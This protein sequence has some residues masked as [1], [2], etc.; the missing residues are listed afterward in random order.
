VIKISFVHD[1]G[2]PG[3]VVRDDEKR[4]LYCYEFVDGIWREPADNGWRV[5]TEARMLRRAVFERMFP[6]IGMPAGVEGEAEEPFQE[7]RERIE[8]AERAAGIEPHKAEVIPFPC[9]RVRRRPALGPNETA[10]IL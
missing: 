7:W 6:G 5:S 8:A 4:T 9:V 1:D 3:L 2:L 10:L